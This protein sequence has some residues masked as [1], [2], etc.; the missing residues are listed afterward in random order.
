MNE[1]VGL[2]T[3]TSKRING[4]QIYY[5]VG[6]GLRPFFD[7]VIRRG[8]AISQQRESQIR[9]KISAPVV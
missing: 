1:R 4:S 3:W 2:E 7:I 8:C 6:P 5:K 9:T